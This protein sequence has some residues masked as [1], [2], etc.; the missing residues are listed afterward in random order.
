[1]S[2]TNTAGAPQP[3]KP[4]RRSKIVA[5]AALT[6]FAAWCIVVAMSGKGVSWWGGWDYE[7][8]G[9]LGDSFGI[10]SAV[11]TTAAAIFTFRTLND[12][13][14][15]T[16]LAEFEAQE[17]KGEA[18]EARSNAKRTQ[19][20][21]TFFR[22]LEQ[23]QDILANVKVEVYD[24][25]KSGHDAI[26]TIVE[27]L[28]SNYYAFEKGVEIRYQNAYE[29]NEDDLGTYF[30]FTYHIVK[31]AE[32]RFGLD[33]YSYLRFLRAQLSGSEQALIGLNCA[34]GGGVGEFER[35]LNKYSL[36]HEMP[37]SFCDAFPLEHVY[38]ERAFDPAG[39]D[40]IEEPLYP[41]GAA[42]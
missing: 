10:I 31:F 1:M 37:D 22:L 42:D 27:R 33:A 6:G 26:Q 36:L 39:S 11:M 30:R 38:Q 9:Q 24:V 32:D 28:N 17:R 21:Q 7:T 20:E 8:T 15:Q 35:L 13:R 40:K 3:P 25:I 2:D 4:D 19:D 34:F 29:S 41:R 12:T 14:R 18:I 23:R 16:E 5:G